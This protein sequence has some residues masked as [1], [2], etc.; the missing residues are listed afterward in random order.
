MS[1]TPTQW[2]T[3]DTITASALNKIENGIANAGGGGNPYINVE[4]YAYSSYVTLGYFV[5]GKLRSGDQYEV[6]PVTANSVYSVA[7][8]VV[9]SSIYGHFYLYPS[10]YPT[11]L[12]EGMVLLWVEYNTTGAT[13]TYS[14]NVSQTLY[15]YYSDSVANGC[16]IVTGN[17]SLNADNG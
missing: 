15:G 11:D 3:G 1:Y 8:L 2:N 7:S 9:N 13:Y 4:A 12:P 10:P 14:G 16:R 6:V 17:F 5:V